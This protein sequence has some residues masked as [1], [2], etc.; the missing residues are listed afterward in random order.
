M[1]R[2]LLI[3]FLLTLAACTTADV[4]PAVTTSTAGES[5]STTATADQETTT[6]S[7]ADSEPADT[8]TTEAPTTTTTLPPLTGIA[9]EKVAGGLTFP[10]FVDAPPGDDR[11]FVV[12]KD[13]QIHIV[14]NGVT[15]VEPFLDIRE[16]TRNEGEQGL[17]GLA[18]HPEYATN[19]LFY[20]H[21][22]DRHG[23]TKVFEYRTSSNPDL[24]DLETGRLIFFTT[25]PASNH[26]GGMLAF[27]PDG[28]LYI[29]LGDGG[30]ADDRYG[31]GQRPDTVLGALLRL[32]VDG[33]D[34]VGGVAYAI[35][36]DNPFVGGG[37]AAEVWAYGLR[38][39]WR[40][41]FD[42][43]LL[44]IGDVGQ[45]R[46]E[47]I[48]VAS[49]TDPGINY[50]WPIMEG[51]NCFSPSS[52]CIRDG[53]RLPVIEFS[54]GEGC[55]VTGGYV[56]RGQ[57]IPELNGRYFYSDYCGGWLRSFIYAAGAA[58]DHQ[59]HTGEVGSLANV[60]SFGT[61][62]FGELY[63]TTAGGDVWKLVGNR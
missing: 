62:G 42:G 21:Y 56:Y 5:T 8:T 27:G 57:T 6:S 11:L 30:G 40:F 55:S 36:P 47:E 44:Y 34:P 54:H 1:R 12:T 49:A 35:P 16:V 25:Q 20:V 10:V 52:G 9:Y 4:E 14:K 53:L 41:S 32:D 48:D 24:A 50:G 63:L 22:S 15:L 26:N 58:T 59:D 28:Y 23:D 13:G 7:T 17:L 45:N 18:F 3:S 37:G 19:G 61:D 38:N 29:G 43:D 39:P 31:N 51:T 2:F 46:W 33:G 60:T